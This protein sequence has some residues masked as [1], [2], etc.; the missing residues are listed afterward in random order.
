MD[1]SFYISI[2]LDQIKEKNLLSDSENDDD[3]PKEDN[4]TGVFALPTVRKRTEFIPGGYEDNTPEIDSTEPDNTYENMDLV[5]IDG[6]DYEMFESKFVFALAEFCDDKKLDLTEDNFVNIMNCFSEFLIGSKGYDLRKHK[7]FNFITLDQIKSIQLYETDDEDADDEKKSNISEHSEKDETS[8]KKELT[9][10]AESHSSEREDEDKK[11]EEELTNNNDVVQSATDD[12]E[13]Y[14]YDIVIATRDPGYV[15]PKRF[16]YQSMKEDYKKKGLS[17]NLEEF[18]NKEYKYFYGKSTSEEKELIAIVQDPSIYDFY[19]DLKNRKQV[20]SK[21]KKENNQNLFNLKNSSI[22]SNEYETT[23]LNTGYDHKMK[24]SKLEIKTKQDHEISECLSKL[25][26]KKVDPVLTDDKIKILQTKGIR[27]VYVRTLSKFNKKNHISEKFFEFS[28]PITTDILFYYKNYRFYSESSYTSQESEEGP[29]SLE[30]RWNNYQSEMGDCQINE[31]MDSF[32]G[33]YSYSFPQFMKMRQIEILNI[34]SEFEENFN[35][36][37]GDELIESYMEYIPEYRNKLRRYY[38]LTK[39][40][41]TFSRKILELVILRI[42]PVEISESVLT[43]MNEEFENASDLNIKSEYQPQYEFLSNKILIL[44]TSAFS[45]SFTLNYQFTYPSKFKTSYEIFREFNSKKGSILF[46]NFY[47]NFFNFWC[48]N[49]IEFFDSNKRGD[50]SFFVENS[51]YYITND[52]AF[53]YQVEKLVKNFFI[54][55]NVLSSKRKKFNMKFISG[56]KDIPVVTKDGVC[57]H[58]IPE[59]FKFLKEIDVN[60]GFPVLNKISIT[61]KDYSKRKMNLNQESEKFLNFYNKEVKPSFSE[62]RN[63]PEEIRN[64]FIRDSERWEKEN[65]LTLQNDFNKIH[66]NLEGELN[67]MSDNCFNRVIK[68]IEQHAVDKGHKAKQNLN[69]ILVSEN[70]EEIKDDMYNFLPEFIKEDND[71]FI[72]N[73]VDKEGFH[74][75]RKI[76]SDNNTKKTS[77]VSVCKSLQMDFKSRI[78][79]KILHHDKYFERVYPKDYYEISE[80]D[81]IGDSEIIKCLRNSGSVLNYEY[82]FLRN[83]SDLFNHM[84][85][86]A[87]M[88]ASGKRFKEQYKKKERFIV[89]TN[90]FRN[91][92]YILRKGPLL[93]RPDQRFLYK[94]FFIVSDDTLNRMMKNE[95][96]LR[97]EQVFHNNIDG[98]KINLVVT[99]SYSITLEQCD[100]KSKLYFNT[101]LPRQLSDPD[102]FCN[103]FFRFISYN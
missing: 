78:N 41:I 67:M 14:N 56:F 95:I 70:E 82:K 64:Y 77:L 40:F 86:H 76:S 24:E 53:N 13:G 74:L 55:S 75:C 84:T 20:P 33:E 1:N 59:E 62:K 71:E 8:E 22:G 21:S 97:P 26:G 89:T 30:V 85:F 94:L 69:K 5:G 11:Q 91:M 96:G 48:Y 6:W 65:P 50:K 66:P 31:Y 12:Y 57:F 43:E 27:I 73:F 9:N 60:T 92:G 39:E 79:K 28:K 81:F 45:D 34:Y 52:R 23:G 83:L 38:E 2:S 32:F 36:F 46:K 16:H 25:I 15:K 3:D 102:L 99:K 35:K 51:D 18:K 90:N 37:T 42:V 87:T 101:T 7:Y 47:N 44:D 72:T 19:Y 29:V 103:F 68:K 88:R 63:L 93:L 4:N 98:K 54:S 61:E 10:H 80:T 49:D 58:S 100:Y 17:L